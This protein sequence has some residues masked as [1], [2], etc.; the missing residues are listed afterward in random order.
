MSEQKSP[1]VNLAATVMATITC[2]TRDT[3]EQN[4]TVNIT[5][6]VVNGADL[7]AMPVIKSA[8]TVSQDLTPILEKIPE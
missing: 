8:S 6:S 7:D 1:L 2:C 4:N 5:G 3:K